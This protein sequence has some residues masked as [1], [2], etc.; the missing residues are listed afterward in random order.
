MLTLSDGLLATSPQQVTNTFAADRNY[1]TPYA[2]TW[3]ASIQHDL[4]KGL[5]QRNRVHGHQRH[6]AGCAHASEPSAAG[7]LA[8]AEPA[9]S[10]RERDRF[11]LRSIDRQ[12]YFSRAARSP[13]AAFQPRY[14]VHGVLSVREVDRRFLY[15]WGAGNTVA[16]NWLDVAAER[17][18]S[19]FDVRHQFQAS[20]VWTSPVAGPGSHMAADSKIGRLLKDWQLSGSLTAQTGNPL[21]ARVLGEHATARADRRHWQRARRSHWTTARFRQRVFQFERVRHRRRLGRM[22]TPGGIRFRVPARSA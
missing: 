10:A 6:A 22:A 12:F 19:S 16:Q 3:N 4:G 13:D 21:T 2:G 7:Q 15:F 18:L 11:Y 5:L 17:G 1:R 8:F 14:F 9:H 20:F